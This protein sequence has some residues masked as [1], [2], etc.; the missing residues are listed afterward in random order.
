VAFFVLSAYLVAA[1]VRG[2]V[3][4]D[5][6]STSPL[7]IAYMSLTACVMWGLAWW[8]HRLGEAM[9]S[10]SLDRESHLTYLD[11]ALSVGILVALV[12]DPLFGWWWADAVAAFGVGIY[13]LVAGIGSWRQG[14]PHLRP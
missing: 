5:R 8:K 2:I 12:V 1:S 14:A 11:S 7:G 3:V 6:P 4:G 9:R 13:A 10:E